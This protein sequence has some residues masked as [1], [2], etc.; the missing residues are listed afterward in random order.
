MTTQEDKM[1]NRDLTIIIVTFNSAEI[2]DKCLKSFDNSKY[3]VFIIDNNSSD[4]TIE[5]VKNSFGLVKVIENSK[6]LGFGRA[7]NIGL[8]QAQT[9]FAL[10]LN[11]DAQIRDIDIEIC[12]NH[13]KNNPQIA[14]ASPNTLSSDNFDDVNIT[15]K[16]KITYCDFVVGGIMFMNLENVKKIGFFDEQFFMFAEDSIISDNS[17]SAGFK[18]AIFN[19]AFALHIGGKSSTKTLKTHYRR[20]WHLGWSKTKYKQ[21]RKNKFN[22]YRSTLRIIL[23]YFCQGIFYFLL[24][25]K[26]KSVQKFAFCFG[27]FASLI[28][29]K[30]FDKNDNP[31]G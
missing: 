10:V 14:L 21:K 17:I 24:R 13:L 15:H 18:N 31:R 3:D 28:G 22:F 25:N 11:P 1:N 12:L 29:M 26:E 19:D 8:N 9:P 5:I 4:N 27:S 7:N 16:E 23:I 6:N 2:I 30:A 20:F